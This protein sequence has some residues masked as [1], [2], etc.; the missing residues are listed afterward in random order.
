MRTVFLAALAVSATLT[1]AFAPS[2]ANAC[3]GSYPMDFGPRV[4]AVDTHN[5]I[6]E[7]TQRWQRRSFVMLGPTKLP[8]TAWRQLAPETFDPTQIAN[9]TTTAGSTT[10]TL[11]GPSGTQVVSSQRR[12]LLTQGWGG[13]QVFTALEV[14]TGA[15]SQFRIAVAGTQPDAKWINVSESKTRGSTAAWLEAQGVKATSIYSSL[16]DGT[17]VQI[18]SAYQ[19]GQKGLTSF[20]R[21]GNRSLGRYAGTAIGALDLGGKR[22]VLFEN[23]GLITPAPV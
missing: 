4:F 18:I 5:A 22:Y 1:S 13:E 11:V 6:V 19:D 17:Y 7:G 21:I 15:D 12:A 8:S 10:M 9:E 16:V 20:V 14:A 3:G 23:D 2:I